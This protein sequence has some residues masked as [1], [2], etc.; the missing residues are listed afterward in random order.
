VHYIDFIQ[1]ALGA[2]APTSVAALGART[3]DLKDNREIPDTLEAITRS[4]AIP[5]MPLVASR[6]AYRLSYTVLEAWYS[7]S[8]V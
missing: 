2:E 1:W 5:S 3:A 4:A 6:W 8:A 7:L